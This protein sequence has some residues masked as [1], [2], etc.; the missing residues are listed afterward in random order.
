MAR[1]MTTDRTAV[2]MREVPGESDEARGIV[3]KRGEYRGAEIGLYRD[4]GGCWAAEIRL[5]QFV[6]PD[7]FG[8]VAMKVLDEADGLAA[9]CDYVDA[10]E[11]K[12]AAAA[13]GAS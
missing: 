12:L 8:A 10:E 9:A 2:E 1:P 6:D 5:R 7:G 3:A 4:A 11:T 13:G